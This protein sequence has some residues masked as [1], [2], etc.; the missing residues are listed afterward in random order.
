MLYIIEEHVY[1]YAKFGVFVRFG[2]SS[3]I[4][5]SDEM[6]GYESLRLSHVCSI[7]DVALKFC[8]G[9]PEEEASR[10]RVCR[11]VNRRLRLSLRIY[12]SSLG[13]FN[14]TCS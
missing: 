2:A 7:E 3:S 10:D 9:V 8:H 6:L 12:Q 5:G 1:L 13:A 14:L 11:I 4:N